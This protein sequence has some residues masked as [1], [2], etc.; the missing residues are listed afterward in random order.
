MHASFITL[1]AVGLV[2]H[3]AEVKRPWNQWHHFSQSGHCL[4]YSWCISGKSQLSGGPRG[5]GRGRERRIIRIRELEMLRLDKT[6]GDYLRWCI[7][8]FWPEFF[9]VKVD[10]RRHPC[11]E[12]WIFP[13]TWRHNTGVVVI[14]RGSFRTYDFLMVYVLWVEYWVCPTVSQDHRRIVSWFNWCTVTTRPIA[15][16]LV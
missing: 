4:S 16:S 13:V 14:R 11:P 9:Q 12:Q 3:V 7:M 2:R 1:N 6:A 15:W 10:A 8:G 5:Q